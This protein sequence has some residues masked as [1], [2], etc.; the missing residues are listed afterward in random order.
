M[1]QTQQMNVYMCSWNKATC[2]LGQW[3]CPYWFSV[4]PLLDKPFCFYP[5]FSIRNPTVKKYINSHSCSF[6]NSKLPCEIRSVVLTIPV[7]STIPVESW[8]CAS[9][10]LLFMQFRRIVSSNT[11]TP[12]PTA[13]PSPSQ[14]LSS[15]ETNTLQV[16]QAVSCFMTNSHI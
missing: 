5:T 13:A 7:V 4:V 10:V 3:G 9:N 1:V 11:H 12:P 6:K 8:S 15:M 16:H 2:G 14:H